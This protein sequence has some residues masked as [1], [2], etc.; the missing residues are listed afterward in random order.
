MTLALAAETVCAVRQFYRVTCLFVAPE[1]RVH[2]MPADG[3]VPV[4]GPRH[5][6][7][8][9]LNFPYEHFHVDWRFTPILPN[10]MIVAPHG[11]VVTCTHHVNG[12]RALEGSPVLK[13]RMCR[14]V[15]PDFPSQPGSR[16]SGPDERWPN[17]ERA[18]AC[19]RLKPGG[20]CPHRGIDL[21]PFAKE[22]GT[23]IC[24]GHGLRWDLA[25]GLP[26]RH[27]Q[28]NQTEAAP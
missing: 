28:R 2:W 18:N 19:K 6:D 7:Q 1:A 5:E 11:R 22:D 24:P 8:E 13:R 4:L 10:D 9:H 3:W 14:R 26:I 25:T 20:I 15:M 21:R 23:A 16:Y 12:K 27:H 17:L